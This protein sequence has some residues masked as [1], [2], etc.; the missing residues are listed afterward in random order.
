MNASRMFKDAVDPAAARGSVAL[1]ST[2]IQT[3]SR[4]EDTSLW[5]KQHGFTL[6]AMWM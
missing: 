2:L 4:A 6:Q 5:L 1:T 3:L